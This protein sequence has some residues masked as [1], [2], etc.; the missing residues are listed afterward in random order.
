MSLRLKGC[1]LTLVES[2][3]LPT[4]DSNVTVVIGEV[5]ER[6]C[7]TGV[8]TFQDGWFIPETTHAAQLDGSSGRAECG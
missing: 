2:C 3:I 6:A 4:P 8:V 1:S 5:W 7:H